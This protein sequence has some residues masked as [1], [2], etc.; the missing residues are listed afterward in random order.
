MSTVSINNF[1]FNECIVDDKVDETKFFSTYRN[2]M[3]VVSDQGDS[4]AAV[5]HRLLLPLNAPK[6]PASTAKKMQDFGAT[7]YKKW[8]E[9]VPENIRIPKDQGTFCNDPYRMLKSFKHFQQLPGQLKL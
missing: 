9:D 6:S 5:V 8:T 4:I 1:N 3:N 2:W 7:L